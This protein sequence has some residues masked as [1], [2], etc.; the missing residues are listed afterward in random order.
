MWEIWKELFLEVLN[1]KTEP[2]KVPWITTEIKGLKNE[3]D[4]LKIE[5]IITKLDTDWSKHQRTRNQVNIKLRNA[6]TNYY[7]SKIFNQKYNPKKA[8]RSINNLLGKQNKNSKINELILEGNTLNNPK[9]IA[10][11]FNNYFNLKYWP[12]FSKPNS[13]IKL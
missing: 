4:K 2:S 5:A 6:K 13:H 3:K 8:W 10:E 1:K 12:R 9:D 7:S 11:D